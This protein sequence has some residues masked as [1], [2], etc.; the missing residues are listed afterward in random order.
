MCSEK[1]ITNLPFYKAIKRLKTSI[2]DCQKIEEWASGSS[3]S[4]KKL[5]KS[6]MK[7][8]TVALQQDGCRNSKHATG[9]HVKL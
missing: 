8:A 4:K 9:S 2:H 1:N 6:K 5:K 3:S 7:L